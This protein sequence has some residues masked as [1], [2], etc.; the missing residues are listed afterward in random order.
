MSELIVAQLMAFRGQ[1]EEAGVEE[2][3]LLEVVDFSK[4]G[5][6]EIAFT[7]QKLIGKPR[8]YLTLSS[9]ELVAKGMALVGTNT[10]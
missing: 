1:G 5:D 3:V 8:V 2:S 10:P 9:P 4:N 7:S 6:I